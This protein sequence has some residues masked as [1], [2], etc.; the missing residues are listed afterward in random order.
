MFKDSV[1]TVI[2]HHFNRYHEMDYII[3]PSKT[4]KHNKMKQIL[5]LL[6]QQM[7]YHWIK[8]LNTGSSHF[9]PIYAFLL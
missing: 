4:V 9:M 2:Q 3:A 8:N 1:T 7:Q 5:S 6:I